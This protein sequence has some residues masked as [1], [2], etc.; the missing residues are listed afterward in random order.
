MG[1]LDIKKRELSFDS[2]VEDERIFV[3]ILEPAEKANVKGVLQI[4]HGM[5]EHSLLYV[6]FAKYMASKG[7]AV[8]VNDHLG[9][10]KSVS[11]GG[12]Y[13]YFG[14]G[15]CQNLVQDMHKLYTLIHR[16]YPEAP[17]ILMGHSLGSL[18]VRSYCAQHG[19][20]LAGAVI[21]GTCGSMPK[22]AIKVQKLICN[23]A[24]KKKGEK[25]HDEIFKK[26]ASINNTRD[27]SL[28]SIP[29]DWISRD[30]DEVEKYIQDPLC[31]F[32]LTVSGYRDILLLQERV[33]S[34][35]WF[36]KM[37]QIPI[38]LISGD[39]DPVGGFGKGVRQVARKLKKTGHDVRLILYPGAKHSILCEINRQEVFTDIENF[40][41]DIL[42]VSA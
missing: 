12:S 22:A 25:G 14:K 18:L 9:H 24:V 11:A 41:D 7:F 6:E 34:P 26:M 16:D 2:C 28:L 10:G 17:Y 38:L 40:L 42:A 29:A 37:P 3:R 35:G 5:S 31:G 30:A 15:G 33:T 23:T 36:K 8:A 21:M 13:G 1:K 20:E 39:S 4:A 32:D 19:S 27:F